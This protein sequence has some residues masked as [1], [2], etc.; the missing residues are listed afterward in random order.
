M[1]AGLA[2]I[3]LREFDSVY[4]DSIWLFSAKTQNIGMNSYKEP[5][6]HKQFS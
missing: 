5:I 3:E 1:Y 6:T 4:P 2:A